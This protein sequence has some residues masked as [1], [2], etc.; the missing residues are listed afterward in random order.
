MAISTIT[1][2]TS[3]LKSGARP[4]LFNVA[5][6]APSGATSTTL[7]TNSNLLCKAA[8][9]PTFTIGMIEVPF[10][11][12]RIK[13]PG[14]RTF[15]E[16]TATFIVDQSFAIRKYFEEWSNFVKARDFNTASHRTVTANNVDY[17]GIIDVLQLDDAAATVKTYSLKDVFPTDVSQID[18]SYDSTDAIEE[19]TVT[20]QYHYFTVA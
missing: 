9:V 4:N 3:Q 11:G 18:V 1:A 7:P 6:T 2:I 13:V 12:R 14:D 20:F 15:A 5:V 19:F 8:Q 17:Y 16:W 10:R